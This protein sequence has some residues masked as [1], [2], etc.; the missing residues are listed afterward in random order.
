MIESKYS[1][2]WLG[3]SGNSNRELK[4]FLYAAKMYKEM[5]GKN[6]V[7]SSGMPREWYNNR[8]CR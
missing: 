2:K 1:L 5:I 7:L 8:L 4:C 6:V 3:H